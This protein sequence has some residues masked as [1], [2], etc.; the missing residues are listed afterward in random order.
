MRTAAMPAP[1]AEAPVAAPVPRRR[2][3]RRLTTWT[4]ARTASTGKRQAQDEAALEAERLATEE[5]QAER[6]SEALRARRKEAED[7][8]NEHLASEAELQRKQDLMVRPA[9][10]ILKNGLTCCGEVLKKDQVV[11]NP[12]RGW[13]SSRSPTSCTWAS[14]P[15]RWS[16]GPSTGRRTR[17]PTASLL[18]GAKIMPRRNR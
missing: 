13:F 5:A 17:P 7:K 10:R 4:P 16:M 14:A 8:A 9:V 3:Q 11:P 18:P 15:R 12:S 1:P 2:R 6:Q